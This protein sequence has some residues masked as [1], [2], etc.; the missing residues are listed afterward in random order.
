MK[1]RLQSGTHSEWTS[2]ATRDVDNRYKPFIVDG[3]AWRC[4]PQ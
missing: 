2:I 4:V 3:S 1:T